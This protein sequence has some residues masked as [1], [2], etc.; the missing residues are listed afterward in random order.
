MVHRRACGVLASC[1]VLAGVAALPGCN[2]VGPIAMLIEGPPTT[3]P[4]FELDPERPT[5]VFV[6]DPGN[7]LPQRS[8]RGEIARSAEKQLL[9]KKVLKDVIDHRGVLQAVSRE[10]FGEQMSITEV[11]RAVSAEVVIYVQIVSITLS[12]DGASYSPA[13]SARVKVIDV[14][15]D[16]RVWPK[17]E[18]AGQLALNMR[19]MAGEMPRS[20]AQ[21]EGMLREVASRMGLAVAQMFYK[22]ERKDS[23]GQVTAGGG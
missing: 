17:E 9:D 18:N 8:L 19:G 6:D 20:I 14:K 5:V 2:V 10:R 4:V 7:A 22:H 13:A 15:N 1:V 3:D 23:A 11:G 21:R 16:V 12:S